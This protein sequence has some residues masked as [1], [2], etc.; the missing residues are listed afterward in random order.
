MSTDL[1]VTLRMS[2]DVTLRTDLDV[3]KIDLTLRTL[4]S[5]LSRARLAPSHM[6]ATS[7]AMMISILTWFLPVG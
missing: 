6:P 1:G 7:T 5:G 2:E 4:S 3:I